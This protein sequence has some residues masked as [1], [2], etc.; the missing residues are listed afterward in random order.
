MSS[1]LD[2]I[3][4]GYQMLAVAE[5]ARRLVTAEWAASPMRRRGPR[6]E[7][8]AARPRDLRPADP[9]AGRRIL[10]GAF[11]FAGETVVHGARGDPWDR[12]SPS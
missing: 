10:A 4:G 11:V 8:F 1:A 5:G 7:G 9:E 3:P 2:G 12:A 6:P